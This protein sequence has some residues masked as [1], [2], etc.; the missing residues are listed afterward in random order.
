MPGNL[1]AAEND[2]NGRT[3]IIEAT[4]TAFIVKDFGEKGNGRFGQR[5]LILKFRTEL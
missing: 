4:E 2:E 1:K 5:L 3:A